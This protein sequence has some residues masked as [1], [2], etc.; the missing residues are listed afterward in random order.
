MATARAAKQASPVTPPS[1][2][3]EP[4]RTWTFFTNHAHVLFLLARE[5]DVRLR[6]V[7]DRVGIT[8]R[9][10][11]RIVAELATAG[12]LTVQRE[13]RRNRYRIAPQAQLRHPIEGHCTVGELLDV[14]LPDEG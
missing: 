6:E 8:E 11:Q 5:P 13:G 12:Y 1:S 2:D 3:A 7:A 4:A 10:V 14:V 9:A